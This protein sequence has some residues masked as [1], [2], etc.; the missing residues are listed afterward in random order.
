MKKGLMCDWE[1]P[2]NFPHIKHL[3]GGLTQYNDGIKF[4]PFM[5]D[6]KQKNKLKLR[7]FQIYQPLQEE[8]KLSSLLLKIR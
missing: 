2:R 5:A 4:L 8:G 7:I 3:N 6:E 1:D